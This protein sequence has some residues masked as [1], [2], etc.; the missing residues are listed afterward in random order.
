MMGH[1]RHTGQ[2]GC[3]P[4][5]DVNGRRRG[6]RMCICV[7]GGVEHRQKEVPTDEAA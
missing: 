6:V 7:F 1:T 2:S 5:M 4:W 3:A